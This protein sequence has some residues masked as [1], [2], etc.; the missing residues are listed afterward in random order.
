MKDIQEIRMKQDYFLRELLENNPGYLD[1][2]CDVPIAFDQKSF[3]WFNARQLLQREKMSL[4][5]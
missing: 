2:D 1:V 3:E 4:L 5:K